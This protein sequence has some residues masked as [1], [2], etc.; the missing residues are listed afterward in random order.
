[1]TA[2]TASQGF[3]L[4]LYRMVAFICLSLSL[5]LSLPGSASWSCAGVVS[6]YSK[7][8]WDANQS[9]G[10]G[11]ALEGLHGDSLDCRAHTHRLQQIETAKKR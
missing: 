11:A 8:S 3:R 4:G 5:S 2:L 1:M 7:C 9:S 10:L 6:P